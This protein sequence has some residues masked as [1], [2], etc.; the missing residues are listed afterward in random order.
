M[1]DESKRIGSE[2]T[3]IAMKFRAGPNEMTFTKFGYKVTVTGLVVFHD[4]AQLS[5][6]MDT[7]MC[8][9]ATIGAMLVNSPSDCDG[10]RHFPQ[11]T[12]RCADNDSP[13]E[14]CLRFCDEYLKIYEKLGKK[15]STCGFCTKFAVV[16]ASLVA[17][18]AVYFAL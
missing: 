18:L 6:L 4:D 5:C 16:A 14:Y 2:L 10:M 11:E 12:S 3:R 13:K 15:Q 17:T 9:F 8:L 1:P 7:T